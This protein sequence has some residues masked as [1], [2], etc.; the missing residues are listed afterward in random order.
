MP[1]GPVRPTAGSGTILGG[2]IAAAASTITGCDVITNAA[3]ALSFAP[4]ETENKS[5]GRSQAIS[6]L[7]GEA[8]ITILINI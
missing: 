5:P 7:L 3:P 1:R 4:Y 6:P 2:S 8:F